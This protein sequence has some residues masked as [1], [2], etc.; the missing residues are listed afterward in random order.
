MVKLVNFGRLPVDILDKIIPGIYSTSEPN[1]VTFKYLNGVTAKK[2]IDLIMN[3]GNLG[4]HYHDKLFVSYDDHGPHAPRRIVIFVLSEIVRLIELRQFEIEIFKYLQNKIYDEDSYFLQTH[5]FVFKEVNTINNSKK[6]RL[7]G[8]GRF[9]KDVY[10]S[11]R[12]YR[13]NL[14]SRL[15]FV[16]QIKPTFTKEVIGNVN[17]LEIELSKNC[18]ETNELIRILVN[19]S[20]EKW[21]VKGLII[22]FSFSARYELE[23]MSL[24]HVLSFLED[25]AVIHL[26]VD[27]DSYI[28]K[29][30]FGS[31][32]PYSVNFSE[33]GDK[34]S[35]LKFLSL[36]VDFE[37]RVEEFLK[38]VNTQ[39]LRKLYII[40]SAE[41]SGFRNM[42]MMLRKFE[43][44]PKLKVYHGQKKKI[45]RLGYQ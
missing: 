38:L 3:S 32:F 45:N 4:L 19:M 15:D 30:Q 40:T 28:G 17:I 26:F 23:L 36:Q 42:S 34:L 29:H 1:E 33:P 11:S 9:R 13:E 44:S 39:K 21:R 25:D 35:G 14:L 24:K 20:Q 2:A 7:K 31:C 6:F 22:K 41:S 8:I 12:D 43:I 5:P 18:A 37:V 27:F 10:Y 16:Y